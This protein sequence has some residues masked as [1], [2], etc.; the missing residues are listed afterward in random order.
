LRANKSGLQIESRT[1]RAV[2]LRSL[3]SK[4]RKKKKKTRGG[5]GRRRR[6]RRRRRGK[7]MGSYRKKRYGMLG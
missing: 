2:T 7:C 5:G 3:V 6:R 4:K 1:A